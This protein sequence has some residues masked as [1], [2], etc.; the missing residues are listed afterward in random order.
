M[1][2]DLSLH[3]EHSLFVH[4]ARLGK[5]KKTCFAR[6]G[7]F[8]EQLWEAVALP[9]G[10]PRSTLVRVRYATAIT[11]DERKCSIDVVV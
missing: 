3:C 1:T 5:K 2:C 11:V 7:L 10:R 8:T 6:S 9:Q 4:D